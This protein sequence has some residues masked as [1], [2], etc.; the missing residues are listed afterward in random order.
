MRV[1]V[2][3]AVV[4]AATV[5]PTQARDPWFRAPPDERGWMRMLP[6]QYML[7]ASNHIR[8]AVS[9]LQTRPA[10]PLEANQVLALGIRTPLGAT[11]TPYLVRGLY[12][13][14]GPS[15]LH[16]FFVHRRE[17]SVW[18]KQGALAHQSGP[19]RRW[20]LVIWL[21][22]PPDTVYVTASVAG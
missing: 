13:V 12:R 3:S 11:G 7:V 8:E 18:V 2:L 15:P 5:F 17:R 21:S 19:L 22:A 16:G 4:A 1:L 14:L 20:P 10:L 6:S 9:R